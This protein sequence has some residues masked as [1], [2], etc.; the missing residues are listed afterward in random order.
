MK[1]LKDKPHYNNVEA[2]PPIKKIKIN[3]HENFFV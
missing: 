3:A 1:W 2:V